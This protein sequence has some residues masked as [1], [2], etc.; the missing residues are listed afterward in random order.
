MSCE[1]NEHKCCVVQIFIFPE[2][3]VYISALERNGTLKF[4]M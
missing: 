4:T 2:E 1:H 3:G